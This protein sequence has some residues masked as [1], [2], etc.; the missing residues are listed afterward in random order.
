[1]TDV[2]ETNC[3]KCNLNFSS[4]KTLKNH[5]LEK[6]LQSSIKCFKCNLKFSN[7]ERFRVHWNNKHVTM[8]KTLAKCKPSTVSSTVYYLNQ[9]NEDSTG[10][11]LLL[12][13]FH[14]GKQSTEDGTVILNEDGAD[15]DDNSQKLPA[16]VT[17]KKHKNPM[18]NS[19]RCNVCFRTFSTHKFALLHYRR[20]HMDWT[21]NCEVCNKRVKKNLYI[22]V[23]LAKHRLNGEISVERI[24]SKSRFLS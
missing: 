12:I 19:N 22:S 1:M 16:T 24:V 13:L 20:V 10:F 18:P 2:N 3:L 9:L 21:I 14:H 23:H 7:Q 11:F 15:S 5:Q 17:T 8:A 4:A 6:H